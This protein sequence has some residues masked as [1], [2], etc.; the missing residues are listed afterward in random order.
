MEWLL[1]RGLAREKKHWFDFPEKLQ[2]LNHRVHMI[3]LPGV[4]DENWTSP[5]L[6]I[7]GYTDFL[8]EKYLKEHRTS[9]SQNNGVEKKFGLIGISFGGMIAM[10]WVSRYPGDFEKLVL[11]NAS[12]QDLSPMSQRISAFGIYCLARAAAAKTVEQEEHAIL[13][14]V[15]NLKAKDAQVLKAN[16]D[17]AKNKRISKITIAKQIA[18]ATQFKSPDSLS[19]QVLV[20]NSLKDRMVDSRCSK[21]LADKYSAQIKF[22]PTAGH[23]LTLDDPEWAAAHIHEFSST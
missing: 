22:H 11:I 10:D 18:T 9:A 21:S 20:L 13:K 1:L 23:D 6:K 17:I 4:G 16:V 15:S 2:A 14:M 19:A 8:R 3:D 5:P 12:A 7:S